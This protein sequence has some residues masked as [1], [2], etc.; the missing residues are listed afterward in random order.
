MLIRKTVV[1]CFDFFQCHVWIK[2][3]PR[4]IWVFP[5]L[6][7]RRPRNVSRFSFFYWG[8]WCMLFHPREVLLNFFSTLFR[9]HLAYFEE[10]GFRRV[11]GS[12]SALVSQLIV[13]SHSSFENQKTVHKFPERPQKCF[14]HYQPLLNWPS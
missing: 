4:L 12:V 14:R 10:T 3:F 11:L 8:R 7:K 13:L 2:I 1:F 5:K 9:F 6:P